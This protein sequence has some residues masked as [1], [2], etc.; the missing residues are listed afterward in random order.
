M[1]IRSFIIKNLFLDFDQFQKGKVVPEL[2]EIIT[3]THK[4]G[5]VHPLTRT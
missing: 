3:L 1:L 4:Y 5:V 2:F